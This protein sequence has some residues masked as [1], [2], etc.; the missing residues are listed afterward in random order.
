M[1][2]TGAGEFCKVWGGTLLKLESKKQFDRL[3]DRVGMG[4]RE[5]GFWFEAGEGECREYVPVV[6]GS[7]VAVSCGGEK[8]FFCGR[9]EGESGEFEGVRMENS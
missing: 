1:T 2:Y 8:A 9:E 7:R 3:I 5:E 4:G 6:G